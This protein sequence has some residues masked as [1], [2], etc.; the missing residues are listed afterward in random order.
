[1]NGHR[2]GQSMVEGALAL[3]AF[4]IMMA[5]IIDAGQMFLMRE[6][7]TGRLRDVTRW[8]AMNADNGVAIRAKARE[9]GFETIRVRYEAAGTP[10]ERIVI[11]ADRIPMPRITP[12]LRSSDEATLEASAIVER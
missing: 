7:A 12:W 4:L 6:T 11:T 2:R 5:V 8:A 10:R 9:A 1:M 3:V